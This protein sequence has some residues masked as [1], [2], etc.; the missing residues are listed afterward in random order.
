MTYFRSHLFIFFKVT[1]DLVSPSAHSADVHHA[2]EDDLEHPGA[3]LRGRGRARG[4][5]GR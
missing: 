1:F 4:A 2:P 3:Q 5:A